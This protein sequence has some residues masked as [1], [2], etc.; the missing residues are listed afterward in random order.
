[1]VS[2]RLTGHQAMRMP[3]PR[4]TLHRLMIVVAVVA[5]GLGV[6]ERRRRFLRLAE[7]YDPYRGGAFAV[8]MGSREQIAVKHRHH[9]WRVAMHKRYLW[10]ADHPWLPL[11]SDPAEPTQLN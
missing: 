2:Y 9:E 1:M 7:G 8:F 3:R 10:A 11:A 6:V 5:V 4:L